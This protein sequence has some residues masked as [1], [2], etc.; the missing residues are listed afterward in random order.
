MGRRQSVL[1]SDD[2][3]AS[4]VVASQQEL[5]D[6]MGRREEEMRQKFFSKVK[7]KEAEL[8][9]MEEAVR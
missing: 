4:S 3:Y 8:R 5:R 1:P 7:E 2:Q 9:E 6:E